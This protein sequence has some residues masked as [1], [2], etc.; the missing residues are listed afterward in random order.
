MKHNPYRDEFPSV[1]TQ[2][3][4]DPDFWLF[5]EEDNNGLVPP[6]DAE[7]IEVYPD[8][9]IEAAEDEVELD[10]VPDADE[11]AGRPT[12]VDPA[13]PPDEFHGTDL[14]NGAGNEPEKEAD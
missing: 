13:A 5:T 2:R 6:V 10:S 4:T 7:L 8:K 9:Q 14:L 1:V 12:P 3:E 11:Y